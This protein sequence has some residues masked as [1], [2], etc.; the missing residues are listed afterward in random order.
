MKNK[1]VCWQ[2]HD[3]KELLKNDLQTEL[4]CMKEARLERLCTIII[5]FI[6]L[7]LRDKAMATGNTSVLPGG[8]G[9]DSVIK[10]GLHEGVLE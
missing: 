7:S 2:K 6:L 10:M 8:Q 3:L 4:P 9:D 5:P 1:R